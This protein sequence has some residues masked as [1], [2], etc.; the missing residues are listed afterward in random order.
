[1]LGVLEHESL[2]FQGTVRPPIDLAEFNH[3][4]PLTHAAL[5]GTITEE[6]SETG[7]EGTYRSETK[8]LSPAPAEA[9]LRR[10]RA[11]DH[12]ATGTRAEIPSHLSSRA[13]LRLAGVTPLRI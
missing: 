9:F 2:L 4:I 1:M 10:P 3:V 6:R 5:E 11:G 13:R 7:T 12:R 8:V